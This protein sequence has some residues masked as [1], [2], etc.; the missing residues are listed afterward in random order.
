MYLLA[1]G[2]SQLYF[3]S[4]AAHPPTCCWW[5]RRCEYFSWPKVRANFPS[6]SAA[7]FPP[8]GTA[9]SLAPP[10]RAQKLKSVP[11]PYYILAKQDIFNTATTYFATENVGTALRKTHL[12]RT[13]RLLCFGLVLSPAASDGDSVELLQHLVS[14]ALLQPAEPFLQPLLAE[15]HRGRLHTILLKYSWSAKQSWVIYLLKDILQKMHF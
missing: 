3:E 4:A 10:K 13:T 14:P 2:E 8:T 7:H 5:V 12:R 11:V 6:D 1:K 9:F 15:L